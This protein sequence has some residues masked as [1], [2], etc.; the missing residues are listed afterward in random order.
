[1]SP[2]RSR[3]IV[4]AIAVLTCQAAA[5]SAAPLAL[6]GGALS[7]ADLDECCRNVAPGQ[8]C[9]MHHTNHGAKPRGPGW[10]CVC[11]PSDL[12]IAS[13]VGVA[14]SLPQPIRVADQE[15]PRTIVPVPPPPTLALQ[16]P[17]QYPPPRA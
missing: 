1:M 16:E 9:P 12:I 3:L 11:S 14:G 15:R 7:A 5:F 6:C 4:C 8:T 17:P 13:I 2:I 10:T